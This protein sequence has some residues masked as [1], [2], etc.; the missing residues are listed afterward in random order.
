[1]EP[2]RETALLQRGG[3]DAVVVEVLLCGAAGDRRRDRLAAAATADDG[4]DEASDAR[5]APRPRL[6]RVV[7][8]AEEAPRLEQE[9]AEQAGPPPVHVQEG[10]G[11]ETRAHGDR[12]VCER[13]RVG[14]RRQ[15]AVREQAHVAKRRRVGLVPV[16]RR[17]QERGTKRWDLA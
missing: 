2:R 8:A 4:A 11:A 13:R 14:E 9:P 5:E 17:R 7:A 3:H 15:P 1:D 16:A 10:E 6:V 12:G